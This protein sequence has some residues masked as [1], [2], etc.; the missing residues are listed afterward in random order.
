MIPRL[1]QQA[2]LMVRIAAVALLAA[3]LASCAG[4]PKPPSLDR[5]YRGLSESLPPIAPSILENRRILID[6]GHGGQF[7]GT[8]GRDSLEEASVNLGVS[9]Y[10]WGLLREAGAD[11]YLTRA[12][13]R[14]FLSTA[15][16]SLASD[17]RTRVW[18]ADSLDPD[19]L[20]SIHHNAHPARDPA[21]N[22]VETYYR[23]G[24]PASLDL[25]FAIHR[26]LMRNLGIERGEVRQGNYL[27]L[28]ES[29]VPAVLGESS[30]LTHPSVEERLKLSESQKL[31]AEAYFL[32]ILEFFQR[33]VPRVAQVAPVDSVFETV[34]ELVYTLEDDG[35]PGIDPDGIFMTLNGR[36]VTP[37]IDPLAQRATYPPPWDLANGP[38]EARFSARNVGGNTSAV[39]STRFAVDFPPEFASF[40]IS[41]QFAPQLGR[42]MRARIRLLDRRGLSV[43]DGTTAFVTTAA[44][45]DTVWAAVVDGSIDAV[46]ETPVSSE[47]LT[48]YAGCRGKLFE[49]TV[50]VN[51]DAGIATRAYHI[52]DA[53]TGLPIEDA[54]VTLNGSARASASRTGSFVFDYR[55]GPGAS[56][57]TEAFLSINA[58]GYV[59]VVMAGTPPSNTIEMT[60]WF[61]GTLTGLRFV[62]DPEGGRATK[63]GIGPLGLSGAHANLQVAR[64]LAGYLRAGGSQVLL[65]RTN[66]E[67]R[68]PEDIARM[69]N[70]FIADR[71]IEVR[72]RSAPVDS[73]LV[74]T[75]YFFPGSSGGAR[76]A[77]DVSTAMSDR[78]GYPG[79][80]P[81][82]TVTYP[83]Q[84]TACPAIVVAAPSI[85]T[86]EEE[87]RLAESWYQREQA[88]AIFLGILGHY[89]VADSGQVLVRL[90]GAD[91]AITQDD[92]AEEAGLPPEESD[93]SGW[94][95]TLDGTW[96]LVT[97]P[98]GTV[99]FD[100]IPP[101]EYRL[102]AVKSGRLYGHFVHLTTGER[103]VVR[104]NPGNSP[105]DRP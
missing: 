18:M 12:I 13:D 51:P 17:L 25:A 19:I 81:Y 91:P 74:V 60:P 103:A 47:T 58:A 100:K 1:P 21:T 104:F 24:D 105:L 27:I 54:L 22:S 6:P 50:D 36:R 46:V 39:L 79:K 82:D 65:T 16:S 45:T 94:R 61:G 102:T 32:G 8:V 71:Y 93:R 34:P 96:T 72:H 73:P 5:L 68:T 3:A 84:Q 64:Y 20:V 42:A 83:L 9:L 67:V 70:R 38:Y 43:A 95:V 98:D 31:E 62:V 86:L 97:G 30:Y 92:H 69:T 15:D 49:R 35:G 10:L 75:A 57:S 28:R 29:R 52:R 88:Y 41:P 59:P 90:D 40:E 80:G 99:L 63:T 55:S 23:A 7:R 85:G 11:V 56:D 37:V 77:A 78:L 33:G 2:R 48:V 66:D 53:V 14:D 101:G 4:P 76:M 44:A 26:H 87:L 89:G